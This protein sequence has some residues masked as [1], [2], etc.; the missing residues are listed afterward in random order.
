MDSRETIPH[1]FRTEFSRITAVLTKLFGIQHIGVAEDVASDTF[2]A[3][4]ETWPYKGLPKNPRAW[5]YLVAKNK[6]RNYLSRTAL[7]SQ[8]IAPDVARGTTG[9]EPDIDLSEANMGDSQLQML[10]AIC[11]PAI[12]PEA[13]VG[14]AL[15]I[16]CGFGIDEIANAFLTNKET[17]NKRLFRAKERLREDAIKIE[18]PEISEIEKR[19]DAVL[20]TLY[21][22]FN[23]GYYSESHEEVL[24]EELCQEAMRLTALL[25]GH[26]STEQPRVHALLA[27]M[28][29][30]SSRF[31]ARKTEG[32]QLVLYEDQQE[33]LWDRE[34]IA[35][36]AWHL[37][38]ASRG[39]RLSRYHLEAGIAYW[40]TAKSDTPAKR[41]HILQLYNRLLQLEYSAIAAL[42][43]TY[44]LSKVRGASAAITEAEKLKLET[45]PYYFALL[46]E[47]YIEIDPASARANFER[48]Y[49]LA[50]TLAEKNTLQRKLER[51]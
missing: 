15:R 1:L 16:L 38:K 27:L 6:A 33:E 41:G 50:G 40:H 2:L 31:R 26:Q 34:L 17:I 42:N 35:R 22:L 32:G 36:G 28:C 21:L 49:S 14:L 7:F 24:R 29:F 19:L 13:Q 11:V 51:L 10:F 48:A 18:F 47:L 4:L 8:K 44:A 12:S 30:H 45:N 9:L 37:Q 23:E 46:G 5:L 43:R 25:L 39:E 20:V 3:A